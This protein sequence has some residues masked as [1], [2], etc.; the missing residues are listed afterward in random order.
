MKPTP[1]ESTILRDALKVYRKNLY[2][3][4]EL[5]E[6]I[7]KIQTINDKINASVILSNKLEPITRQTNTDE[8]ARLARNE[9]SKQ[10]RR[11]HPD[12]VKEY[13]ANYWNKKG[14]QLSND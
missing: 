11:N 2:D 4:L 12:K 1:E 14:G 7:N 6:D 3:Q 8:A 10:W 9:Y 13:G 5:T